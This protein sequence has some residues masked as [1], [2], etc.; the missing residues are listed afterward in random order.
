MLINNSDHKNLDGLNKIKFIKISLSG[1]NLVY[2]GNNLSLVPYGTNLSSTIG[3]KFTSI[4][5]GLIQIPNNKRSIIV[6][7]LLSDAN[8]LKGNKGGDARL[9][10]K[11]MYN[12]FEYFYS[13]FFEL[14]HYCSN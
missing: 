13:V 3:Y 1:L 9:A 10:F 7:I 4:E 5:R 2:S 8:L 14:I 6:G 11:Q 12:H